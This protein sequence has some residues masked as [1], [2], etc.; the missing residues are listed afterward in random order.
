M[1]QRFHGSKCFTALPAGAWLMISSSIPGLRRPSK[2]YVATHVANSATSKCVCMANS[3]FAPRLAVVLLFGVSMRR[4]I[5]I[6]TEL[7]RLKHSLFK[8]FPEE[9]LGL[10]LLAAG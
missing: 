7:Q 1:A 9:S 4:Q 5:V 10:V 2:G 6:R 8:C 3:P